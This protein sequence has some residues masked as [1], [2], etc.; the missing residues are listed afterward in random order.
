MITNNIDI[1]CIYEGS[2][3]NVRKTAKKLTCDINK[4]QTINKNGYGIFFTANKFGD[5][6]RV[7]DLKEINWWYC[8]IDESSKEKQMEKIKELYLEPTMIIESKRGYHIYWKGS[9]AT[10]ENFE[11]VEKGI[12]Y[13]L[14]GDKHVT[15][16]AHLLR[17]PGFYHMK[18]ENDPF[19][20]KM[21]ESNNNIYTEQQMLSYFSLPRTK[22]PRHTTKINLDDKNAIYR[23]FSRRN[24]HRFVENSGRRLYLVKMMGILKKY[25][26]I[27]SHFERAD[28]IRLI[29]SKMSCPLSNDEVESV[30]RSTEKDKCGY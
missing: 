25:Y 23:E 10:L 20:I 3:K 27:L 14:G 15:D 19:L 6:R 9:D 18:N 11:R 17:V 26:S 28:I 30:I 12:V 5:R 24:Y 7:V 2:N 22:R 21:V 8:D 13:K 29:N 16:V 1:Y 4:I